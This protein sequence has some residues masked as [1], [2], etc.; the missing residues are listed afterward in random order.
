MIEQVL[1]PVPPALP[2]VPQLLQ[3]LENRRVPLHPALPKV[4]EVAIFREARDRGLRIREIDGP[5][6]LC[7]QFLDVETILDGKLGCSAGHGD[8]L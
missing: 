4:I 7:E 3:I 8:P 6:V 1:P 5:R 2:V